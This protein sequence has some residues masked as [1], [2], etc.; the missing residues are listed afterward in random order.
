MWIENPR[1]RLTKL[2]FSGSRVLSLVSC[3]LC[4]ES[5][6]SLLASQF[7]SLMSY[8]LSLE[9]YVLC[10]ASLLSKPSFAT[11]VPSGDQKKG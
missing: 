8:V 2:Q 3:V 11:S 4:L 5:Y 7:L 10:L 9:S 1:Y 6:V